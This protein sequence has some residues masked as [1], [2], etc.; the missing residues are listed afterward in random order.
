M[1]MKPNTFPVVVALLLGGCATSPSVQVHKSDADI[2][3]SR[4][5]QPVLT[6]TLRP[7]P[8]S[9]LPLMA[10]GY[11]HPLK[12]P[13]GVVV[14]DFVPEDHKHHRGLFLA[15]VEM[16]GTKDADFW[17]WG[18]HAPVKDRRIVNRSVTMQRNGFVARNDWIAEDTVLLE[19]ELGATSGFESGVNVLDLKYRLLPKTDLT[20]SRWAFSGFCLRVRKEG[21]IRI[22]SPNGLVTLPNP[23]H[24]KPESDWPDAAWYACEQHLPNGQAIGAAVINHPSNP[25]TLWHNHRDVRMI[26]PCIVAPGEV[27]LRAG[28]PLVLRYRVVT[29][30][31]AIPARELDKLAAEFSGR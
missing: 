13:A 6:Y 20:L 8:N 7:P 22:A 21:D 2:E 28:Q 29:F 30:D 27:K 23:S 25:R 19:E 10:G 16:H 11:F 9:G 15:W 24:V 3:L 14:T 17:G 4:H 18:A 5:G 31:G 1:K 26:N 12:T